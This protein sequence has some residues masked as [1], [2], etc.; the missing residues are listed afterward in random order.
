MATRDPNAVKTAPVTYNAPPIMPP[1][2]FEVFPM[3]NGSYGISW[4]DR[5]P[6]EGGPY[7]YQLLIS[8]GNSLIVETA[9]IIDI[10]KPPTTYTNS[11]FHTYSFAVRIMT[12]IGYKSELSETESRRHIMS[13]E[14]SA[15]SETSFVAIIVPIVVLLLILGAAFTVFYVRYRNL[16]NRF[17]RFGNSHYDSRSD[18]ATFDDDALEEDDSPQ[19][20]GFSA[21]EPLVIA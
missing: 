18:A 15:I 11:S 6:P 9:E 8:E 13:S 4:L 20:Q 12:K 19:I 10:Y 17:T 2:E 21:D 14:A 16:H 7:Y 5:I 3:D 1:I